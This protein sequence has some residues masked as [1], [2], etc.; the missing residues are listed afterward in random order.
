MNSDKTDKMN[1]EDSPVAGASVPTRIPPS[2]IRPDERDKPS[3]PA[4]ET[5]S[6]PPAIMVI[7]G[8]IYDK[9][10]HSSKRTI[11]YKAQ[12][13]ATGRDVVIKQ[14]KDQEEF[15]RDKETQNRIISGAPYKDNFLLAHT[16]LDEVKTMIAPYVRGG[17]LYTLPGKIDGVPKPSQ[18]LALTVDLFDALQALHK[19]NIVH[20]DVKSRN[21]LVDITN[22]TIE[23]ITVN[24]LES[25]VDVNFKLFDFEFATRT[26]HHDQ[27]QEGKIIGTPLYMAPEVCFGEKCDP[28]SDI[29]S[30]VTI[31]YRLLAGH[32]PIIPID[33]EDY[34]RV[35][36]RQILENIP[37]ITNNVYITPRQNLIL[38]K[39]LAKKPKDRY[40][41]A[42]DFKRD[43]ID[44]LMKRK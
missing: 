2:S 15:N 40:Q 13:E 34:L 1:V 11:V 43:W 20:R 29:Y 16:F 37:D 42:Q 12:D 38:K 27:Y 26:D 14:F 22:P 19:L 24:T 30:A 28:R 3:V 31:L 21:V 39:G 9:E 7:S 5:K 4:R 8:Y 44:E 25:G 33:G 23:K 18:T 17:D 41:T 35:I 36:Q 32:Y 10:L 6:D